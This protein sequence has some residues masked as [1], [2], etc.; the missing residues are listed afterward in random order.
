LKDAAWIKP[1]TVKS[2]QEILPQTIY[3][4]F[5][6]AAA[7]RILTGH[8]LAM[9]FYPL[10]RMKELVQRPD[11]AGTWEKEFKFF[12]A[13]S[14]TSL[15]SFT[16]LNYKLLTEWMETSPSQVLAAIEGVSPT[17]IRNRLHTARESGLIGK[18]GSG[19]TSLLISFLTAKASNKVYR[20][21]FDNILL[22]MPS[23]S[24]NS[25]KDN[26]FEHHP[27]EKMYNELNTESITDIYQKLTSYSDENENTLLILDDVGASLKDN[28]ILKTLKTIIYNRR[29]LKCKIVML[30]QSYKS[31]PLDISIHV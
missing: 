31:S 4:M 20:K 10:L 28:T 30:I 19:K 15:T 7:R 13:D 12:I 2:D 23:H 1:F 18:P 6:K 26:I 17:T 21:C 11:M 8:I 5:S 27:E 29:H 3:E 9:K 16:A 24:R 25:L 22:V 14:G